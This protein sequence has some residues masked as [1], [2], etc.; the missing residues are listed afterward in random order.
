MWRSHS[1]RSRPVHLDPGQGVERAEGLVH[2]EQLGLAAERPGQ[3]D[4]LGLAAR[5]RLGPGAARGRRAPPP[6]ARRA[7]R[8]RP[9]A[10]LQPEGHVLGDPG[11]RQQPGVLEHDGGPGRHPELAAEL[12]VEPGEDAQQR[13]LAAAAAAEQHDELAAR[14]LEVDALEHAAAVERARLPARRPAPEAAPR[15][16]APPAGRRPGAPGRRVGGGDAGAAGAVIGPPAWS[17]RPATGAR[18]P[19]RCVSEVRPSRA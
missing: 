7:A 5:E 9:P 11:P 10:P 19:G 17:A 8:S 3:R 4:P 1:G 16:A 13:A 15:S 18:R 2:Q 12:G 14:D 6:R